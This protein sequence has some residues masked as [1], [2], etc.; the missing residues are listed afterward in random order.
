MGAIKNETSGVQV[1]ARI[2]TPFPLRSL[3]VFAS[4]REPS[5]ISRKVAKGRQARKEEIRWLWSHPG[6]DCVTKSHF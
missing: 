2:S 4:W 1:Q 6:T 5:L 3:R